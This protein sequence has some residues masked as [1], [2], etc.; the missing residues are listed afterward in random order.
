MKFEQISEYILEEADVVAYRDQVR[1]LLEEQFEIQ[2]KKR[3]RD[4]ERMKRRFEW[5]EDEWEKRLERKDEIVGDQLDNI[6]DDLLK[7][8]Q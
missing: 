3:G 4:I 8:E 6:F 5:I 2:H 7:T 1:E